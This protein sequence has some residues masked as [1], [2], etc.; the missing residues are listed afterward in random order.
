MHLGACPHS[1]YV[2]KPVGDP[3]WRLY[4]DRRGLDFFPMEDD[5]GVLGNLPHSRPGRRSSKRPAT[6]RTAPRPATE[7][8]EEPAQSDPVGNA[9][10]TATGLAAAGARVANGVAREVV[11]RLPRP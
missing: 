11:R 9:I 1:G 8:I 4:P 3:F 6:P 5:G 7:R 2:T 10:R